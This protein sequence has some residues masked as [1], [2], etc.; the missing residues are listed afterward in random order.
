MIKFKMGFEDCVELVDMFS[1][2]IRSEKERLSIICR[3][4]GMVEFSLISAPENAQ[5][6]LICKQI[7][8]IKRVESFFFN[9]A[10]I[11][12]NIPYH[13]ALVCANDFVCAL[14]GLPIFRASLGGLSNVVGDVYFT[15]DTALD[16][17]EISVGNMC[18]S[19]SII[20]TR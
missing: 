11:S 7:S 13:Q 2:H 3:G 1:P 14:E 5:H 9:G 19:C 20:S 10:F 4:D 15:I 16:L 12:N 18:L 17:C 6:F 8:A